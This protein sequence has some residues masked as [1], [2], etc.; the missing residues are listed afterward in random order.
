M[1]DRLSGASSRRALHGFSEA[2]RVGVE[3]AFSGL[4]IGVTEQ[5]LVGATVHPA[6]GESATAFVSQVVPMQI[7]VEARLLSELDE[8]DRSLLGSQ[9]ARRQG[10]PVAQDRSEGRSARGGQSLAV[11]GDVVRAQPVDEL[12]RCAK[13]CGICRVAISTAEV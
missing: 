12:G 5:H 8:E 1:W 2:L 9:G 3:V 11:P 7:T 13:Y 6:I 10:R 4:Q